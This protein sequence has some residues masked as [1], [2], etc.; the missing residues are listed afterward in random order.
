MSII[1]F[2]VPTLSAWSWNL[3]GVQLPTVIFRGTANLP[4]GVTNFWRICWTE[5]AYS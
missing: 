4:S 1:R 5:V 2:N 3:F